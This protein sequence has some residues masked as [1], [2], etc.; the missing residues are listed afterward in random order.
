MSACDLV[1][2]SIF[3]RSHVH[4]KYTHTHRL[5]ARYN[6]KCYTTVVVDGREETENNNK[7]KTS[8]IR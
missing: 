5:T 7:K 8:N 6:N 4:H 1:P 3:R 2:L